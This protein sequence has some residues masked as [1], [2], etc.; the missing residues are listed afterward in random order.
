MTGQIA[1]LDEA[2]VASG[3]LSLSD[4]LRLIGIL[5]ERL[6][7]ELEQGI[8]P[9]DMLSLAGLGAEIWKDLDITTY[10]EQERASWDS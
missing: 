3:M 5:S 9:V 8:E 1:T 2:I 10:L 4:Q 7:G 6:R